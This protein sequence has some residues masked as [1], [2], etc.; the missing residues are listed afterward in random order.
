MEQQQLCLAY[1][2]LPSELTWPAFQVMGRIISNR[3]H[4]TVREERKLVYAIFAFPGK[5]SQ[6]FFV[7]T[8]Y[9]PKADSTVRAAVQDAVHR[10]LTTPASSQEVSDAK[11]SLMGSL[12]S[13]QDTA[14]GRIGLASGFLTSGGLHQL[15]TYPREIQAVT[16]EAV[17][18]AQRR[19]DLSRPAS[20]TLRP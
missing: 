1:P 4:S 5:R 3:L 17:Q 13:A 2:L 6:A 7:L 10:T 15:Q 16:E 8:G 11:K 20:Y 19:I 18:T 12:K 14:G 9:D